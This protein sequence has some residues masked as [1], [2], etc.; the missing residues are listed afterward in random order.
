M[1]LTYDKIINAFLQKI[2]SYDYVNME[3]EDFQDQVRAFLF[4]ACSDFE[5]VF[6]PRTGLSF[7]D[8]DNENECFNWELPLFIDTPARN[9]IIMEEEVVEIVSEGMVLRWLSSFLYAGDSFQ[10]ANFMKT[11]DFSPYSPSAFISSMNDLYGRTMANYRNLINDF[12]YKH[13][14]LHNLH[15]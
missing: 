11:K 1:G 6:R 10:L 7:T 14:D 15:M 9:D 13:G 4:G 8:R 12:S 3:E 5:F 2:T